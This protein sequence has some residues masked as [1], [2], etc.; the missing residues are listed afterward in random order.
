MVGRMGHGSCSKDHGLS[1][2]GSSLRAPAS[3]S[4][5]LPR[6]QDFLTERVSGLVAGWGPRHR[7]SRTGNP[8]PC[9]PRSHHLGLPQAP[10]SAA[11]RVLGREEGSLISLQR[12]ALPCSGALQGSPLLT[13]AKCPCGENPPAPASPVAPLDRAPGSRTAPN[14]PHASL[15]RTS[16][17]LL[18]HLGRYPQP[19]KGQG[20]ASSFR[21]SAVTAHPLMGTAISGP[22]AHLWGLGSEGL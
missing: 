3:L 4:W 11:G 20:N 19:P 10:R 5:G 16:R 9:G 22:S 17:H 18:H 12:Q 2:T 8:R 21:K 7:G 13:R 15:F 6:G 14:R 1:P